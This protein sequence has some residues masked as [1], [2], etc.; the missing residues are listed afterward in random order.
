M[1]YDQADRS[2]ERTVLDE[3]SRAVVNADDRS[4]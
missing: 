3:H 1:H 4:D 2:A